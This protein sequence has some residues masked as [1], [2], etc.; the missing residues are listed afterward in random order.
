MGGRAVASTAD[1]AVAHDTPLGKR[2]H[3][4]ALW[5]ATMNKI[6]DGRTQGTRGSRFIS[7]WGRV[8]LILVATLVSTGCHGGRF[9]LFGGYGSQPIR[10]I[11]VT[12]WDYKSPADIAR[13]M[14][15]SKNA[16]FNT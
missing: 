11:W 15:K 4:L 10:A 16:G 12:R 8:S 6:M 2:C 13:V 1:T 3:K 14:D 7:R 5:R 9:G